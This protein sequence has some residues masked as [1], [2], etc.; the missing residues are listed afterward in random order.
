MKAWIKQHII[1]LVLVVASATSVYASMYSNQAVTNAEILALKNTISLHQQ[2]LADIPA[3]KRDIV[4]VTDEVAELR[5]IM[6][7]LNESINN[8]NVTL[9]KL[10]VKL[11]VISE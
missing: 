2:V 7:G 3:L 6:S 1:A 4:Y 11:E 8:L 10:E 9:A 5:P